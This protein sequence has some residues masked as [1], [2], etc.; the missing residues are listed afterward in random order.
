MNILIRLINRALRLLRIEI[1]VYPSGFL[2]RKLQLFKTYNINTIIDVGANTGQYGKLLKRL[3][4]KG[5][6]VS[7]EPL[8]AAFEKL[9]RRSKRYKNWTV[10]KMAIGNTQGEIE[11]NVSSNS[12]S[13]SILPILQAHVNAAPESRVVN[14]EKVAINKLDNIFNEYINAGE[15]VFLKIDTQGFEKNVLEGAANCLEKI[16]AIQLE[17]SLTPM[18]EGETLLQDMVEYLKTKGFVLCGIE[19][20]F[21][22]EQTGQVFQVDGFFVRQQNTGLR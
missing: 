6:I 1:T 3:G 20:E 16:L 2:R 13:S 22:S 14:K 9:T 5:N 21:W 10:A 7:F 8:S 19:E 18:Y 11:I 15:N 12:V 4:Y 17:M